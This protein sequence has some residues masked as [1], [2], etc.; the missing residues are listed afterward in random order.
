MKLFEHVSPLSNQ[1]KA[2]SALVEGGMQSNIV[3]IFDA[4]ACAQSRC[5][6]CNLQMENTMS[7]GE[8]ACL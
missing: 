1:T 7:F 6:Q 3:I 5:F 2:F 4:T 8:V